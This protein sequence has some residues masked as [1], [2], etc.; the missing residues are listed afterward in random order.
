MPFDDCAVLCRAKPELEPER[1]IERHCK[2][3]RSE[4]DDS[5]GT[6]PATGQNLQLLQCQG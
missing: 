4:R 2:K 5:T 1:E 3:V 6:L